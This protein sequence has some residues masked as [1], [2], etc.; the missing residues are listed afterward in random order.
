MFNQNTEIYFSYILTVD[1]FDL[2]AFVVKWYY[3]AN[4]KPIKEI[5]GHKTWKNNTRNLLNLWNKTF[6]KSLIHGRRNASYLAP[7]DGKN[8]VKP[9]I[10]NG[11]EKKVQKIDDKR[12]TVSGNYKMTMLDLLLCDIDSF[13]FLPMLVM[14]QLP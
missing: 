9:T 6:I 14:G 12:Q 3:I 8:N 2:L 11:P 4:N 10:S 7:I 1:L 5:F 13:L